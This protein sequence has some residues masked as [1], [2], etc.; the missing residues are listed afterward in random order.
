MRLETA[1]QAHLRSA[2]SGL[3]N[4]TQTTNIRALYRTITYQF[5][6]TFCMMGKIASF[7]EEDEAADARPFGRCESGTRIG[8]CLRMA[9]FFCDFPIVIY[10]E[11]TSEIETDGDS[12]L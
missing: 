11:D 5:R 10:S 8:L 9:F 12:E 2:T 3:S 6:R 4:W 1:T 7:L